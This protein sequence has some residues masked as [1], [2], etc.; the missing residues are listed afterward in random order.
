MELEKLLFRKINKEVSGEKTPDA[1][2]LEIPE[3]G[4]HGEPDLENSMVDSREADLARIDALEEE[5]GFD[6]TGTKAEVG[7]E[8]EGLKN[9][10]DVGKTRKMLIGYISSRAYL[11][12]LKKEF[13]GDFEEAKKEQDERL[14]RLENVKVDVLASKDI[15]REFKKYKSKDY[16]IEFL[17]RILEGLSVFGFYNE[18]EHKVIVPDN[19]NE[20][21][22]ARSNKE[23]MTHEVGH[24]V[25]KKD[26]GIPDRT[27]K[28]LEDSYIGSGNDSIADIYLK[29]G[30][31][32]LVRKQAV[33]FEMERLGIKGYEDEFTK[34]HYDKLMEYYEKGDLSM[35]AMEFIRTTK[36]EYFEIIFNEIAENNQEGSYLKA[37]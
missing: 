9:E 5:A 29:I 28:I 16:P 11:E 20:N 19:G 23:I 1:S 6:L 27:K 35:D 36:P 17:D 7:V 22:S 30:T 21:G 3:T 4:S 10:G 13:S 18:D 33:D 31:E 15:M 26:F 34:D 24:A 37:A 14:R 8:I 25:T 32:R 2:R 12:R